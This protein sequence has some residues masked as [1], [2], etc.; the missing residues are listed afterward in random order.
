MI[1][2]LFIL[3]TTIS[4]VLIKEVKFCIIIRKKKLT[5]KNK[6]KKYKILVDVPVKRILLPNVLSKIKIG[7]LV[8]RI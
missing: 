6:T 7:G 1:N 4:I 5:G 2:L 3:Y 8:K